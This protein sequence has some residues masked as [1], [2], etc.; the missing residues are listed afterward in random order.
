MAL[1]PVRAENSG[2]VRGESGSARVRVAGSARVRAQLLLPP[3]EGRGAGSTL[4]A[5]ED[6]RAQLPLRGTEGKQRGQG[7]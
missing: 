5:A 4:G 1:A 6:K 7:C 2:R 3:S